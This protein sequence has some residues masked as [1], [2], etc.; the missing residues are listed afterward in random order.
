MRYVINDD[1]LEDW[2]SRLYAL[3]K[4]M[5]NYTIDYILSEM[6]REI[7]SNKYL[8]DSQSFLEL[9]RNRKYDK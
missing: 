4:E 3:N 7:E 1:D 9:L 5:D 2:Y 8:I 6:E